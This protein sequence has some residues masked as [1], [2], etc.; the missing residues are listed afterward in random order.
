MNMTTVVFVTIF[1]EAHFQTLPHLRANIE[2][3][4][5]WFKKFSLVI[6][7]PGNQTH[8]AKLAGTDA[9]KLDHMGLG[10]DASR[11][12]APRHRW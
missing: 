3:V 2:Q 9:W 6:G 5:S 12:Q 10:G 8:I 4:G 7:S 1:T 11:G